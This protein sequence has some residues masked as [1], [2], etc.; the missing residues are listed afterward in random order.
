MYVASQREW[1]MARLDPVRAKH[2]RKKE[3]SRG[4][5]V[6]SGA[7]EAAY[8]VLSGKTGRITMG[9]RCVVLIPEGDEPSFRRVG[10]ILKPFD[11]HL[12]LEFY[13]ETCWCVGSAAFAEAYAIAEETVYALDPERWRRIEKLGKPYPNNGLTSEER[14]EIEE[15]EADLR[16]IRE[17]REKA[18]PLYGKPSADCEECGGT[19]TDRGFYNPLAEFFEW[20]PGRGFDGDPGLPVR[21]L[22][23][24]RD[25][26]LIGAVVTPQGVW[27]G[28]LFASPGER[29]SY[30][31]Y[32]RRDASLH[33]RWEREL[34]TILESN[35]GC[36]AMSVEFMP[37]A[38]LWVD[39]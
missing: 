26:Y 1:E 20:G 6:S 27:R 33:Q 38:W 21:E 14:R 28:R 3:Q 24:N 34:E 7:S 2:E 35:E 4:G 39:E 29:E 13:E 30:E 17:Q 8:D 11:A 31:E 15:H 19:G 25:R 12:A 10:E 18:H 37:S 23:Q 32:K 36:V 16:A 5:T 22:L 9:R